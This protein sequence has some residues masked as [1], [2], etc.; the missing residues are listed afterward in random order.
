MLQHLGRGIVTDELLYAIPEIVEYLLRLEPGTAPEIENPP[1][2]STGQRR[3]HFPPDGGEKFINLRVLPGV[4]FCF[5]RMENRV[6]LL[7]QGSEWSLRSELSKPMRRVIAESL[8]RDGFVNGRFQID[9]PNL[10]ETFW[11][12]TTGQKANG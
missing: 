11:N 3:N 6:D 7:Y 8:L 12:K 2:F 10:S 5:I 4:L 1:L 9:F